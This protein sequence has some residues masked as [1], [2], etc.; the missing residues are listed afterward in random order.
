M[1]EQFYV[2]LDTKII[3]HFGDE[4]FQAITCTGTDDSKQTRENTPKT[5]KNNI[6]KLALGKKT[7]KKP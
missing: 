4:S 2:V 6:N 5:Q 1:S 7:Q 3:G